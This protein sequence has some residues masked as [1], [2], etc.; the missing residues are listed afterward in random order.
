[1]SEKRTERPAKGENPWRT[2]GGLVGLVVLLTIMTLAQ[3]NFQEEDAEA[4]QVLSGGAFGYA[5]PEGKRVLAPVD[6]ALARG[7]KRFSKVVT[8]PGKV[9]D[10]TFV[11]ARRGGEDPS[12]R[13]VPE[14]FDATAGA[15]FAAEDGLPGG[16]DVLVATQRFLAEREVLAL[17]PVDRRDCSPEVRAELTARA[18]RELAWC[19]DLAAVSDGGVLS[20]ARYETRGREELVTLAYTGPA[21]PAFCD[22]PAEADPAGTWRPD[23]GGI[24]SV[25]NYQP[26]FAFRTKA[27]LEVAVRWSRGDGDTLDLYRQEGRTLTPFLAASWYRAGE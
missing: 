20:L 4:N 22:H 26:L 2:V 24:F 10:V 17:S 15:V 7:M 14:T 8:A 25:E 23:D 21:G 9:V 27:G 18:G 19:K 12:S 13:Q 11:E 1:M 3:S 16:G 5:D 6:A